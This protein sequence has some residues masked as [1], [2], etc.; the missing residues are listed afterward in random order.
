MPRSE[1]DRSLVRVVPADQ[2][3]PMRVFVIAPP[4]TLPQDFHFKLR[5]IDTD[6]SGD[7][8]KTRFDTPGESE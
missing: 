8:E 5:A 2:T 7:S 6:G 1:A 3:E 4:R